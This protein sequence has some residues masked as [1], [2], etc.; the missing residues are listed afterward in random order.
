MEA[1]R[2]DAF[3]AFFVGEE[4]KRLKKSMHKRLTTRLLRPSESHQ[5]Q[6]INAVVYMAKSSR[7]LSSRIGV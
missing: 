3:S 5:V 1:T 4:N 7:G 2:Q 6:S